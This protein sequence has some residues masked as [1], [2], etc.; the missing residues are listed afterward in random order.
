MKLDKSE[1]IILIILVFLIIGAFISIKNKT[2]LPTPKIES[3][4]FFVNS[5]NEYKLP[6]YTKAISEKYNVF[7]DIYTSNEKIL[8]YGIHP[9]SNDP[10]DNTTFQKQMEEA[11]KKSNLKYKPI[12]YT[13]WEDE[14]LAILV[15]NRNTINQESCKIQNSDGEKIENIIDISEK[16]FNRSCIIDNQHNKYIVI[17]RDINFIINVLNE[18]EKRINKQ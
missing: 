5:Q 3:N 13:D 16:C 1:K 12:A 2:F 8:V 15:R 6:L 10:M 7:K 14:I 17:S 11:L 9:D 4:A 18:H